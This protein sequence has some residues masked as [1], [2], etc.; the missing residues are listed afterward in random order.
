[1]ILQVHQAIIRFHG[2]HRITFIHVNVLK[3]S[4]FFPGKVKS[5]LNVTF[6]ENVSHRQAIFRLTCVAILVKNHSFVKS[7]GR[8]LFAASGDVQRHIIIHSGE[9]PHLCD[10]CGRGF[11]NFSNLK[12][13]KKNHAAE[14]VFTCDECGKSFN[15]PR[16]LVKHRIR[17]TGEKPYNC[18]VCGKRFAGSGDLQRHI[19][20]HTGEKPYPCETCNKCFSRSAVLRRHKKTHCKAIVDEF[21]HAMEI[22]DLEKSQCSDFFTQEISVSFL[23]ASEKCPPHSKGHLPIELDPWSTVCQGKAWG[24][25]SRSETE[26]ESCQTV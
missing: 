13:H 19:R 22:P 10:I 1:M 20:T 23:S 11:S 5:L 18:S 14:K 9:K 12:E 24:G 26:F 25:K 4:G 17:H 15:L 16:K 7:V 8:G 6:V 3:H 21:S 2:P